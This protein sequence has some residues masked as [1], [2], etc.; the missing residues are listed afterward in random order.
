[1][2]GG[3]EKTGA[4]GLNLPRDEPT[5]PRMR[6]RLASPVVNPECVLEITKRPILMAK[7]TQGGTAGLN[8]LFENKSDFRN[9]APGLGLCNLGS[10]PERGEPG[11]M[12]RLADIDIPE[13]RYIFLVK[14]R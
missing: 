14:E 10:H 12:K 6:T 4:T 2:A 9:E 13:T 1:M 7:I 5:T 8:R 3:T 11:P